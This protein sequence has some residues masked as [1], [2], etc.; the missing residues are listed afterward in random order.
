MRKF[1]LQHVL[2]AIDCEM[3]N[4]D[5]NIF[6]RWFP[7]DIIRDIPKDGRILVVGGALRDAFI[8]DDSTREIDIL[9]T[10]IPY[11]ELLKILRKY[12]RASLVG[13]SFSIIKWYPHD[14]S[15]VDVSIP[16]RRGTNYPDGCLPDPDMPI[17]NDLR[18]RDF[19]VN[20]MAFDLVSCELIDPFGGVDDLHKRILRAVHGDSL[21]MDPLRCLRAGYFAVKCGLEPEAMTIEKIKESTP[22]LFDI[23]PE[24]IGEEI[25]KALL[26]IEKPSRVIALWLEWGII[27]R[28]MPELKE[29]IGVTQEGGWHAH[30]VFRHSLETLDFAPPIL[31]V[32]LSALFHDLGKPKRRVYDPERDR[33]SFY[34]HQSVGEAIA[35]KIMRRFAFSNDTIERVSRLV[36]FHMFTH[37]QTEKGIRRFIRRVGVDLL[38]DLFALRYADIEAQGTERDPTSDIEYERSIKRILAEK[39]PLSTRDLAV[40]GN[41]IMNI[42]GIPEGPTVGRVLEGLLEMVLDDP[43]KNNRDELIGAIRLLKTE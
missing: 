13:K 5:K 32:R 11:N 23:A 33:A 26:F 24:R 22:N 36:R 35:K 4:I 21:K 30:D 28:I 16:S 40:D 29:A 43:S 14:G 41:D 3:R 7:E 15:I 9:V 37:A 39:P 12:G 20:A 17:E 19:T 38:D 25:K 1:I 42:L 10:K 34:G 2:L 6:L 8:G 31:D 27:D 18:E